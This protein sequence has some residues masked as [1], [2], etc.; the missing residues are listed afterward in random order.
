MKFT[1]EVKVMPIEGLL[2]PQGK[3]VKGSLHNLG[4]NNIKEVKI[5]K[6]IILDVEAENEEEAKAKVEEAA[7]KLLANLVMESYEIS[8]KPK[9]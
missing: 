3:A 9:G 5:G 1:A 8:I 6:M 4:L 7:Q 2:D